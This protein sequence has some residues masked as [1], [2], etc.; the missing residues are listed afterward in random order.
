MFVSRSHHIIRK[1][2][3]N[4]PTKRLMDYEFVNKIRPGRRRRQ[5]E[6]V[7][8]SIFIQDIIALHK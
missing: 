3:P 5:I 2:K 1:A 6:N 8:Q 7:I 4:Q